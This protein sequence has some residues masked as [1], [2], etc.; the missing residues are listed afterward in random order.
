MKIDMIVEKYLVSEGAMKKIA[1]AVKKFDWFLDADGRTPIEI[2][3]QIR[4]LSD[5]VLKSWSEE[6][7][8]GTGRKMLQNKIVKQELGRR[9]I[10]EK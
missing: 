4:G 3:D 8:F 2:R 5:E 10:S 7:G 1:A 6:S 9:G